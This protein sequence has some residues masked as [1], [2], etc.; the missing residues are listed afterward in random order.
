MA[1]SRIKDHKVRSGR[2]ISPW[3]HAMGGTMK[4]SSWAMNRLPEYIWLGLILEYYGRDEGL[5]LSA[6]ILKEI[7][8]FEKSLDRPRLSKILS[9]PIASQESIYRIM[10]RHIKKDVLSPLTSVICREEDEVF[11]S[12][13]HV[14]KYSLQKR[15]DIMQS[16]LKINYFH[17]SNEATDIRYLVVLNMIYQD[18]IRFSSE[19]TST[20]EALQAYPNTPHEDE[21]MRSYRPMVRSA[22]MAFGDCDTDYINRFWKAIGMR[23]DCKLYFID[24]K[25]DDMD[26]KEFIDDI[27]EALEFIYLKNKEM[28]ISEHKFN[29]FMAMVLYSYKIFY[30]TAS[31]SIGN[32]I[33]SR[34]SAR[35]IAEIFIML[36]YLK[37]MSYEKNNIWQEYQQYGIG[38]YKLILLKARETT[39]DTDS[40]YSPEILDTLVNEETWEEFVDSDLRYFDQMSIRDKS[41][42]VDEKELFDLLYDYDSNYAHGL[43][44]AI[45]ESAMVKCDCAAHNYHTVPDLSLRQ[46]CINVLPDMAKLLKRTM[47]LLSE[48]FELPSWYKEKYG[49]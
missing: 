3:N 13:V 32:T 16:V 31:N 44:G 40:H 26:Y 25:E 34:S 15:L 42:Y 49:L 43:W 33:T 19:V 2:V 6:A 47:A 17:Q 28:A 22:E 46:K 27:S 38:K 24:H 37:K 39:I 10:L 12:Y 4:F 35:I 20:I 9:L 30:E 45:R 23:T 18:K 21:R 8:S 5:R 48:E 36:K 7:S 29:V 14:P 41:I 11:W 1:K